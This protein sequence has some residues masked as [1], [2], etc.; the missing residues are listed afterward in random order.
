MHSTDITHLLQYVLEF[1]DHA[2][3][4]AGGGK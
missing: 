2:N 1:R 4:A 3:G